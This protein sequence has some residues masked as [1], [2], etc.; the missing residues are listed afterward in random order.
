ME[1]R[2][3]GRTDLRMTEISLGTWG[4]AEQSYG[5]VTPERFD[6]TVRKALDLGVNT[7]DLSPLWG[8]GEGERRIG[9]AL[10]GATLDTV[11]VTRGGARRRH[12]SLVQSFG[13]TDLIAD[14]EG[15][16]S[17]LGR[18]TIDLWLLHNPGDA[19]LREDGWREAVQRLEEDGKIRA[20][21]V[22]AGDAEEA[23]LAL[24]AG[25]QALCITHNLLHPGNLSDLR[26]E[27][28]EQGCGVMARSPL[29]YGMLAGHW[30]PDRLFAKDDHRSH[31]WSHFAF[32]ERI[33]QVNELRFLVGPRHPDLATAALRFVLAD[34]HVT[35]ATVGARSPYQIAAAVEAASGPPFMSDDELRRLE[36]VRD[37]VGI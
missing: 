19:T 32:G 7:F 29:M 26:E 25:A 13:M 3:L 35:S 30:A 5:R 20:W 24:R 18:E 6:E 8:D 22:S 16:L 34:G 14:C 37:E 9:R 15:S 33:R 11:V 27:L 2:S 12:G 4:L 28:A 36:K 31:R 1:T 23:R 10:A 17:R 21:G